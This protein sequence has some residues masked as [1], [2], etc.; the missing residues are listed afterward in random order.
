MRS[1]SL[2]QES[3]AHFPGEI[4]IRHHNSAQDSIPDVQEGRLQTL[5]VGKGCRNACGCRKKGMKCS[6][7]CFNC[8]GAS[9]TNV[10]E[11]IKNRP[12]LDDGVIISDD[13]AVEELLDEDADNDFESEQFLQLT[14]PKGAKVQ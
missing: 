4:K 3:S 2:I 6:P 11:D 5:R 14:S 10:P 12:N 9:C 8:R 1:T 13:V 7:I